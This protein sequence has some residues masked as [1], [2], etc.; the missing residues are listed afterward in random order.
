MEALPG[1]TF[2]AGA[3]SGAQD[4]RLVPT[5]PVQR[6]LAPRHTARPVAGENWE[7]FQLEHRSV[8]LRRQD[9]CPKLPPPPAEQSPRDWNRF[10]SRVLRFRENC[11]FPGPDE[12]SFPETADAG[13]GPADKRRTGGWGAG[14]MAG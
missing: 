5:W 6:R 9:N 12:R 4:T 1:P 2:P 8:A 10:Q 7:R 3:Q 13:R 11:P 14:R